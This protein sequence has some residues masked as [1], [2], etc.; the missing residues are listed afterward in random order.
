M[1]NSEMGRGVGN[2]DD[3]NGTDPVQP[4]L[5]HHRDADIPGPRTPG[6]DGLIRGTWVWLLAQ[7]DKTL[8]GGYRT[9]SPG[10]RTT[11]AIWVTRSGGDQSEDAWTDVANATS[12]AIYLDTDDSRVVS[13]VAEAVDRLKDALGVDE[14]HTAGAQHG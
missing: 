13:R 2:P 9:V 8:G 6:Q 12:V 4:P 10:P 11:Q 7:I 14:D 3:D 1:A 5:T